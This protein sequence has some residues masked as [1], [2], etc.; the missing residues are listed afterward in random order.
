MLSTALSSSTR[1]CY[2]AF[3]SGIAAC[4][5]VNLSHVMAGVQEM[6]LT[7]AADANGSQNGMIG[8]FHF[9]AK[10]LFALRQRL[11]HLLEVLEYQL[12]RLSSADTGRNYLLGGFSATW[13]VTEP[14]NREL[15][16]PMLNG[17]QSR[18]RMA[19]TQNLL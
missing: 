9:A 7:P 16:Q 11:I 4:Q 19:I 15:R 14:Q 3:Y 5:N 1:S 6:E 18:A 13:D 2:V 10:A 17:C 8:D 12:Q